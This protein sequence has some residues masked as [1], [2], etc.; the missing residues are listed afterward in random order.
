MEKK[1]TQSV[2]PQGE[3]RCVWM[4]AGVTGFK[5]CDQEFRC[6]SCEFNNSVQKRQLGTVNP[7]KEEESLIPIQ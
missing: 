5:L 4:D 2:I 6:E 1:S 3:L 7:R